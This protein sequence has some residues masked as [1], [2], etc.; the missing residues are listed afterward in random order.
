MILNNVAVQNFTGKADALQYPNT[1]S[2]IELQRTLPDISYT[3]ENIYGYF[4]FF[5]QSQLASTGTLRTLIR[6]FMSCIFMNSNMIPM[7]EWL[8]NKTGMNRQYGILASR[9]YL[10]GQA[11]ITEEMMTYDVPLSVIF[12][13]RQQSGQSLYPQGCVVEALMPTLA[14]DT[15]QMIQNDQG[16]LLYCEGMIDAQETEEL[17]AASGR[18]K[19][20]DGVHCKYIRYQG[21]Q[22]LAVVRHFERIGIDIFLPAAV[23]CRQSQRTS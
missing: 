5:D 2:I 23:P 1:Y 18:E 19:D 22:Y 8:Q 13:R 9:E 10:F 20:Y 21:E 17:L 15:A 11:G 12:L 6:T 7:R 4:I 3:N 16:K 14:E